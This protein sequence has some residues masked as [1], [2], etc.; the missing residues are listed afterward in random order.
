MST[1]EPRT[2]RE[3]MALAMWKAREQAFPLFTRRQ[4]PD[5]LDMASGAWA[6]LLAMADAALTELREPD[7]DMLHAMAKSMSPGRRPTEEWVSCKEKHRI[8]FQAA[9]DALLGPS[10]AA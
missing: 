4:A 7:A 1:F 6:T 5:E 9:I 8:R 10:Q 3:R 2:T